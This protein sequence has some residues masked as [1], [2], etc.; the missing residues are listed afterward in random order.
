MLSI[1]KRIT[2]EIMIVHFITALCINNVIFYQLSQKNFGQMSYIANLDFSTYTLTFIGFFVFL[3]IINFI[4]KTN[5]LDFYMLFISTMSYALV[6]LY[7]HH[8]LYYAFGIILMMVM[9]VYY[10]MKDDKL[11]IEKIEVSKYFTLGLII[12]FGLLMFSFIGLLTTLRYIT[13]NNSTFDFGIF[14][15]MFYYMKKTLLPFVTCERDRLLSHFAVHIS[16]I[17]YLILPIY[18]IFPSPITLQIMQAL[19]VSSGIIPLYL[20]GKHYKLSNKVLI[21][22]AIAYSTYPALIGGTFYDLHENKFLTLLILW[23]F[24]FFEKK[25]TIY[26]Y[27][28][29]ILVL[30]VKEDA[31]LYIGAI[32]LYF[33]VGRKYYKHGII[34]L[35][36]SIIYFIFVI[37]MLSL[38]GEGAMLGR[39]SN[40][41]LSPD[42]GLLTLF[43]TIFLNP[44]YLFYQIFTHKK[45][46]FM[47]LT[48]LPIVFIPLLNKKYSSFILLIPYLVMNLMSNYIYQHSIDFQYTYGVSG[49]FFY[50]IVINL[51]EMNYNLKKYVVPMMVISSILLSSTTMSWKTNYVDI[52]KE[53][54]KITKQIDQAISII[55][56]SASVEASGYFVPKLSSRDYIY[57]QGNSKHQYQTD[58]VVLDLRP[59]RESN[60]QIAIQ[61]YKKNG[62]E[63]IVEIE[64][65]IVILK[66]NGN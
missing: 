6:T 21:A 51:K 28:F 24:Y 46:E 33:I 42:D 19:I 22:I 62:Y 53:S 35:A 56:D 55:P 25:K 3:S 40:F 4:F 12:T 60:M 38:Y 50:L 30:L 47:L 10:L 45:M 8:E 17:Y 36:L 31:P 39:Y 57:N 59:G 5:R 37:K 64:N 58:Y 1:T 9:L 61:N 34:L 13:Y 16:P 54:Y 2:L 27:L 15:Q 29:A 43:K 26:I 18:F 44:A 66:Q 63:V 52:Y 20:I 49:I 11:K 23:L 48:L 7:R 14:S 32:S 65:V 41:M